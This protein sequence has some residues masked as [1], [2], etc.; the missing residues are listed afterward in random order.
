MLALLERERKRKEEEERKK[1][2]LE[3]IA[4]STASIAGEIENEVV[5]NIIQET[6]FQTHR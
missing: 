5:T 4:R 2:K 6:A 1:A 3:S